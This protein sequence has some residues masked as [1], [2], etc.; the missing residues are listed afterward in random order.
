LIHVVSIDMVGRHGN[1][2][3]I[4][5][6]GD[7]LQR[8]AA[9]M[10]INAADFREYVITPALTALAPAGI[11][12]VKIA[13]DLLMVTA[14]METDLGTWLS[15]V[16]GPALG[17]FQIDPDSLTNLMLHATAAQRQALTTISCGTVPV[18]DQIE[19]NL[20]LAAAICRL[21]YCQVPQPLPPD[22]LDGLWGYY[23]TYYNTPLGAATM[24]DFTT[25]FE[26]D[27]SDVLKC[28][29]PACSL[30]WSPRF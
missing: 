27:R 22:T 29:L 7:S 3:S 26:A 17:V 21:F 25:A 6:E 9:A 23:K 13:A 19:G 5:R 18:A 10:T 4:G 20:V 24:A 2:I 11:T 28:I 12:V 8:D 15:Q 30:P 14:A 16:G 1:G